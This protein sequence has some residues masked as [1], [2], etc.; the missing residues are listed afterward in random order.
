ME[1]IGYFGGKF[2]KVLWVGTGGGKKKLLKIHKNLEEELALA[3]WSKDE[4]KFSGHLT[5]GRIKNPTV[6]IKL[7][8]IIENYHN[9]KLGTVWVDSVSVY[10]SQL[11]PQGPIYTLLGNYKLK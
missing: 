4:R 8:D 7:A 10:H 11:T 3:G 9:F 2:A 1:K 5:I 6:G